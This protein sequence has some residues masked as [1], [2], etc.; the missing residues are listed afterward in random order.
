MK[1]VRNKYI[2][3]DRSG[4]RIISFDRALTNQDWSAVLESSD[5]NVAVDN[6]QSII[7]TLVDRCFPTKQVTLSSRDLI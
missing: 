5:I 7:H 4:H 3:R 1:P 6:L 2:L